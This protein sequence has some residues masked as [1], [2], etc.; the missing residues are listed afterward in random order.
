[1]PTSFFAT[2]IVCTLGHVYTY[3]DGMPSRR[4]GVP[5]SYSKCVVSLRK[6][7]AQEGDDVDQACDGLINDVYPIFPTRVAVSDSSLTYT[8]SADKIGAK[9]WIGDAQPNPTQFSSHVQAFLPGFVEF[10]VFQFVDLGTGK[11]L[12]AKVLEER[13]LMNLE[14]DTRKIASGTY[15]YRLIADG[16]TIGSHKLIVVK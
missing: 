9:I 8:S 11:V 10:A 2:N 6:D 5:I 7:Y 12:S 1:M 15:G 13:G 4:H 3:R 16:K 14:V